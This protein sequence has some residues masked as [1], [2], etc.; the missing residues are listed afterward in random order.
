MTSLLFRFVVQRVKNAEVFVEDQSQGFLQEG[1]MLF[2]G[3]GVKEEHSQENHFSLKDYDEVLK[4]A[5]QKILNLRVFSTQEGSE[6]LLV[7]QKGLYLVSQFTLYASLE[8]G[9]RPSYTRALGSAQAKPVFDYFVDLV[10]K[11]ALSVPIFTGVFGAHME[12]AMTND[13]PMTFVF[14]ADRSTFRSW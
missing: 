3:I 8:K 11:E 7:A 5:A 12:I 6:S 1:L 9:N 13:G 2:V 10:K 14:E 4:K